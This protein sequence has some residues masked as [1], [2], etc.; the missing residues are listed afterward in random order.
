ML[1]NSLIAAKYDN[2]DECTV[3][4]QKLFIIGSTDGHL[5]T[6]MKRMMQSVYPIVF[7]TQYR[8]RP[9]IN[10][11]LFAPQKP[12]MIRHIDLTRP[13][14]YHLNDSSASVDAKEK[15]NNDSNIRANFKE[16][17][18]PFADSIER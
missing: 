1:K 10:Y 11:N 12:D 7:D 9:A 16:V 15:N 2:Y 18:D 3:E 17:I 6:S 4:M 8:H 14:E 5:I 13:S